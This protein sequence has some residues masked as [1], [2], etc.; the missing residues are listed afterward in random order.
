MIVLSSSHCALFQSS[1]PDL[2]KD[3]VSF[4]C[5]DSMQSRCFIDAI[6][7][8]ATSFPSIP[9]FVLATLSL[10]SS[11]T[12]IVWLTICR[13]RTRDFYFGYRQRGETE[14][15]TVSSELTLELLGFPFY[16][17]YSL[18][19]SRRTSMIANENESEAAT[20]AFRV[21]LS[22]PTLSF[23][24]VRVESSRKSSLWHRRAR[25]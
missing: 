25:V 17:S 20:F 13:Y 8:D 1:S 6:F 21:S 19:I 14:E 11:S 15:E 7:H 22:Q 18:R 10:I 16:F 12:R 9:Q 23:F 3:F 24:G 4:S 2:A 5:R